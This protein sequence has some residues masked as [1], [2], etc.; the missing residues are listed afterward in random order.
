MAVTVSACSP[1]TRPCPPIT[2][3]DLIYVVAEG[4]HTEIGIPVEELGEELKFYR[5]VFPKAHV[6]MFGYGKKTFFT[7]PPDTI[8]EY[9]LGPVPGPA[10]IQTVALRV[11]PLEAYPDEYVEATLTLLARRQPGT[12]S[13][14]PP[15]PRVGSKKD[16]VKDSTGKPEGGFAQQHP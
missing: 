3:G 9:I 10:A 8:S 1:V 4:W 11:T 2:S 14:Y 16:L 5:T 12:L 15:P 13:L 6:I 7:A